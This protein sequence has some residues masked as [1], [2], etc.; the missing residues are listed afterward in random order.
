VES[1][2]SGSHP[3]CSLAAHLSDLKE[4]TYPSDIDCVLYSG[5]RQLKA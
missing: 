1:C 4:F 5:Y 2:A 3:V